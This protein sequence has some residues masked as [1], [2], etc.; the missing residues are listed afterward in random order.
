MQKRR[1]RL[2]DPLHESDFSQETMSGWKQMLLHGVLGHMAGCYVFTLSPRLHCTAG[3]V[4]TVVFS[5]CH[6][7]ACTVYCQA[8]KTTP[9]LPG[10][11]RC[12]EAPNPHPHQP[13]PTPVLQRK[14]PHPKFGRRHQMVVVFL[15][16]TLSFS[17]SF[18]V[19]VTCQVNIQVILL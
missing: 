15:L 10:L 4:W 3:N 17:L 11:S 8:S 2:F 19:P 18:H 5:T 12:L 1:V 16:L 7:I 14:G 9:A 6:K 13:P